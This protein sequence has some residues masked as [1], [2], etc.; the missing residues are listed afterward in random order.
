M[1]KTKLN[2]AEE[3]KNSISEEDRESDL[4]DEFLSEGSTAQTPW[5]INWLDINMNCVKQS[6]VKS[7]TTKN[8]N[9][10]C[11]I[12]NLKILHHDSFSFFPKHSND[13]DNLNLINI[14]DSQSP[15]ASDVSLKFTTSRQSP[16]TLK[17]EIKYLLRK[18]AKEKSFNSE[19]KEKYLQKKSFDIK[20][21][22]EEFSDISNENKLSK[23]IANNRNM[24]PKQICS[25]MPVNLEDIS[26]WHVYPNWDLDSLFN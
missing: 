1:T 18:L 17:S 19:N 9:I 7:K 23:E 11:E 2:F 22:L 15:N 3:Y 26:M 25:Y 10:N 6:K 12:S 4:S 14:K 20:S 5:M 8:I 13:S 16:Q 21:Q 24:I